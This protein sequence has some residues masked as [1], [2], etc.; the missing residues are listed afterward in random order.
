M[1]MALVLS[2]P[3]R[4]WNQVS[5]TH[6]SAIQAF[7]IPMAEYVRTWLRLFV[8]LAI[9]EIWLRGG[10]SDADLAAEEARTLERA[11]SGEALIFYNATPHA[12]KKGRDTEA[13]LGKLVDSVALLAFCQGELSTFGLHFDADEVCRNWGLPVLAAGQRRADMGC[14]GTLPD[15]RRA[16]TVMRALAWIE[17]RY[18]W[19]DRGELPAILTALVQKNI[20]AVRARGGVGEDDMIRI[21]A[22][23]EEL[24]RHGEDLFILRPGKTARRLVQVADALAVLTFLPAGI[25]WLGM[26][27]KGSTSETVEPPCRE[28]SD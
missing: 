14:S 3:P 2:I 4:G 25:T 15:P 20:H 10:V 24:E 6:D 22:S 26:H 11:T 9:A 8:P 7:A 28:M 27:F 18:S 23:L 5:K 16:L 19:R 17:A 12:K 21:A 1:N 13:M